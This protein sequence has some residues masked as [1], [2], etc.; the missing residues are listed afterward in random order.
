GRQRFVTIGTHGSPWTP[1]TARRE[2]KR[3]LGQVAGGGDPQ[4]ER[5]TARAQGADTFLKGANR[6]LAQAE[7]RLRPRTHAG[8]AR[9]LL[10]VCRSLHKKPILKIVRRDIAACL[11]EIEDARGAVSAIQARARLSAMF[12]WA[13]AEGFEVAANPVL[14]TNRPAQPRSRE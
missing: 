12:S 1:D 11:A 2:A 13:I 7:K 8:H 3:L 9:D 4:A 14:G 10:K 6:Y 5:E